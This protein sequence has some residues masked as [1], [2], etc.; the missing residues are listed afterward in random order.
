MV[1]RRGHGTATEHATIR[2]LPRLVEPGTVVVLNNSRVRK[3][4]LYGRAEKSGGQVE[5][6]LLRRAGGEEWEALGP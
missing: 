1:L 2:E 5:F 4:R 6:L 3:A